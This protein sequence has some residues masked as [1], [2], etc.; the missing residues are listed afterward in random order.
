MRNKS[1][2]RRCGRRRSK[3]DIRYTL[4][5]WAMGIILYRPLFVHVR[6]YKHTAEGEYYDGNLFSLEILVITCVYVVHYSRYDFDG[7][8]CVV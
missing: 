4:F 8:G 7:F 2:G 6:I 1:S 5:R 3:V